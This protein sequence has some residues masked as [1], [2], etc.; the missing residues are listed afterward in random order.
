MSKLNL[1]P[2]PVSEE[3]FDGTLNL[4]TVKSLT[5]SGAS[6]SDISFVNDRFHALST[7]KVDDGFSL[8]LSVG[9]AVPVSY[10]VSNKQDAYT[11]R[12]SSDGIRIDANSADGLFYGIM[13]LIQLPDDCPHLVI[14]D[15]AALKYRIIH[16]DLKGHLPKFP[17]LL[18]EFKRLAALK[19][20]AV[21]LE[22]ED[23]YDFRC[24]PGIGVE[25]A[26]TFD[27]MRTLSKLAH[28]LH[29]TIIP[30]FQCIAHVDYI[31]NLPAYRHLR[32]SGSDGHIFQFC[33]TNDESQILWNN[34]CT[35]LME[36]FE[37]HGPY[38][39]IGAD[40]P[41]NLGECPSCSEL[42]AYGC[43][44][45]RINKCIDFICAHG[46]TPIM[47]DDIVRKNFVGEE[48][49][50]L[51]DILN[52]RVV[53]MYWQYGY[54]AVDNTFPMIEKYVSAGFKVFGSGAYGGCEVQMIPHLNIRHKNCDAWMKEVE[55][56]DLDGL[57]LTGWT[58]VGSADPCVEPQ[59]VAWFSI[60]YAASVMWNPVMEPP[61]EFVA[62]VSEYLYGCKLD[63]ALL[64]AALNHGYSYKSVLTANDTN[65]SIRLYRALAAIPS[66][67]GVMND[68]LNR[69]KTYYH[70]LGHELEDYRYNAF[71]R[72]VQTYRSELAEYRRIVE[73]SL[74]VYYKEITVREIISTQFDMIEDLCNHLQKLLEG[75]KL[76]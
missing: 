20:N 8:T 17:V 58:R 63:D 49:A 74:A 47:W 15:Y 39:H 28:D 13:T 12:V 57:C 16:W 42:G 72:M 1:F 21:L 56:F 3:I 40:E 25:G 27:E 70:K 32:E 5:Y 11:L 18:A 22:I 61:A 34:M 66:L 6:H 53:I 62:Y 31:L 2:H 41:M 44:L 48:S 7:C 33:P 46:K 43:Y 71:V 54:G 37:E 29:I 50:H 36:C 10:D 60:A 26:Y 51:R 64:Q 59:E 24:A 52:S 69:Y 55:K 45:Y 65:P 76:R 75:T 35:E 67:H 73:E 68:M 38:F 9:D 30:K 23:K 4:S 19:V 14:R